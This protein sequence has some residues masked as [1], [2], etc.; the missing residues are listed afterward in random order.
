V[1]AIKKPQIRW[2][3]LLSGEFERRS[4][5]RDYRSAQV[6]QVAHTDTNGVCTAIRG[7][8]PEGSRK[9]G[10]VK[11]SGDAIKLQMLILDL[12][13]PVRS[14]L[15]FDTS[16]G[17][18]P[19]WLP[20]ADAAVRSGIHVQLIAAPRGDPGAACLPATNGGHDRQAKQPLNKG[21]PSMPTTLPERYSLWRRRHFHGQAIKIPSNVILLEHPIRGLLLRANDLAFGAKCCRSLSG[22]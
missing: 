5:L 8:V 6:E 9:P 3:F 16:T 15:P 17:C 14:K 19:F 20:E 7:E 4:V 22:L 21:G 11:V 1:T 2:G 18:P 12:G 10:I 13:G